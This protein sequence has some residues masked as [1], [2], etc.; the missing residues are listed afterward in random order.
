MKNRFLNLFLFSTFCLILTNCGQTGK[1]NQEMK[2]TQTTDSIKAKIDTTGLTYFVRNVYKWI[3]TK[4]SK[5][6][7]E[8]TTGQGQDS[9]YIGIDWN[10]H[11]KRLKELEE[12]NFF[13]TDFLNNYNRIAKTIDNELKTGKEKWFVGELESYG[14]D[15]NPWCD[16]QDNPDNYWITMKILKVQRENND[17]R[18]SWS[19]DNNPHYTVI[20]TKINNSWRIKY[21]QGFDYKE[22]LHK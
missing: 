9:L 8:P 21:L 16:C 5:F 4:S 1:K 6:D 20:A 17:I 18:F 10:K 19:W 13:T 3:E 12:T 11:K 14:N 15:A 22:Y 2:S 7:F